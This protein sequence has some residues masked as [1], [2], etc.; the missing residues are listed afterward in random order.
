MRISA[1]FAELR[2]FTWPITI[3]EDRKFSLSVEEIA[4]QTVETFHFA[5]DQEVFARTHAL[6]LSYM[7]AAKSAHQ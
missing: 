4:V 5:R 3:A 2:V 7:N 1:A 6:E